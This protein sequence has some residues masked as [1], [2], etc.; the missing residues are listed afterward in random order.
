MIQT[1][2][3]V[4]ENYGRKQLYNIGPWTALTLALF[5][6]QRCLALQVE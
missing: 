5:A 1:P 2:L 6:M 4:F 3:Q